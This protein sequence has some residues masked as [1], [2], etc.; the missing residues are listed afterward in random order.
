MEQGLRQAGLA[1]VLAGRRFRVGP[2]AAD[3]VM[4]APCVD[5]ANA[6]ALNSDVRRRAYRAVLAALEVA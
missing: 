4:A 5:N 1:C 2:V 6:L 3:A